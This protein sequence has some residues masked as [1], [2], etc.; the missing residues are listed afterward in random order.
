[1]A[2]IL[3]ADDDPGLRALLKAALE[4]M[5]HK[6]TL[7]ANGSELAALGRWLRPDLIVS[8]IEM[9]KSAGDEA[10]GLL[11]HGEKGQ[12]VPVIFI[13]GLPAAEVK[14]RLVLGRNGR[15]LPKPL[16]FERLGAEIRELLGG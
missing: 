2:H 14:K 4:G 13:S 6:I 8:D 12:D 3:V 11:R 16:D 5:G 7:A 10:I 9:P 1:M 15:F